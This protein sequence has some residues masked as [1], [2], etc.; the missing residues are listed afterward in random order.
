VLGLFVYP[1]AQVILAQLAALAREATQRPVLHFWW[2]SPLVKRLL[3]LLLR[4]KTVILAH[5]SWPIYLTLPRVL[6]LIAI[7]RIVAYEMTLR[8][9]IDIEVTAWGRPEAIMVWL[10]ERR[11]RL[12]TIEAHLGVKRRAVD[13]HLACIHMLRV[14][15]DV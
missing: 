11:R 3:L 15:L 8:V 2:H 6:H 9:W 14:L 7:I 12:A 1:G 13:G 5:L 10:V 4:L